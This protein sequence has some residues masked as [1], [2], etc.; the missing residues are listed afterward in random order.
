M[1]NVD[2]YLEQ[3]D[4]NERD[5]AAKEGRQAKLPLKHKDQMRNDATIR[6]ELERL[7]IKPEHL[8]LT[9]DQVRKLLMR[10]ENPDTLVGFSLEP[11]EEVIKK[12][13]ISKPEIAESYSLARCADTAKDV[14]RYSDLGD[15]STPLGRRKMIAYIRH[16]GEEAFR[17][18]L[19]EK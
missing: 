6:T 15:T 13:A 1:F 8:D 11:L 9:V 10:T 5:A 14:K 19:M 3:E 18:L 12:F 16:A 7:E 2:E 17:N 4:N